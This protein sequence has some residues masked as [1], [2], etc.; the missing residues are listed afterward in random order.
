MNENKEKTVIEFKTPESNELNKMV[1]EWYLKT[2]TSPFTD[3]SMIGEDG[4]VS[5]EM[6][7]EFGEK[8]T[9]TFGEKE[10]EVLGDYIGA[11]LKTFIEEQEP[12]EPQE[13][14]E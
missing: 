11:L 1:D 9:E 5:I 4:E 10:S 12:Q 8:I 13:T 3:I 14:P 6:A 7:P 2:E